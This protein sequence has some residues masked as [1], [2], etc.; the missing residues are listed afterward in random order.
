MLRTAVVILVLLF[1]APSPPTS[2]QQTAKGSIEGT[3]VRSPTG[4]P[5]DRARVTL[6]RISTA[7]TGPATTPPTPL[8]PIPPVQTLR[9][10][11]FSFKALD[12]GQYRLRVQRN[13]FAA[14]EY[15]Q[16][17]A[18]TPG[19]VINLTE[20]QQMN[21]VPFRLIPGA[22]VSGR[23][24]DSNGEPVPGFQ[25]SLM[26]TVYN[27]NGQRSLT[28]VGTDS[29]DDR[30]EYRVFWVPPGRYLLSVRGGATST[31]IIMLSNGEQVFTTSTNQ[32]V[33]SDRIF[34]VTY[35]PGTLDP[36]RASVVDLQ[37]GTE[38]GGIDIVLNQP[39]SF[40][41]R[42]R[43]VDSASSKP[44]QGVSV[45][46]S[47]RQEAGA[48]G[49]VFA[50]GTQGNATYNAT[51][52]AFEILNVIPGTYWLRASMSTDM[53]EPVN[54][55]GTAR[56]AMELLDSVMMASTRSAQIP[57]E[58]TGSDI[59]GLV[60]P[61][62]PGISIPLRLHLEG[63]ELAAVNGLDR[64]RVNLRPTVPGGSTPYQAISFNAEGTA[65]LGNVSPGEYRVQVS[66]PS[67]EMYLK[68]V[69]FD[70]SDVLTRPWEITS[71]TSGT[72][73]IVFSNKGGQVEGTLLDVLSQP[74]RGN[75]VI[76]IPDEG[77]DRPEL[78]KTATTDA[79]GKFT[80]RGVAPGGYRAYSWESIEANAWYD[81]EI[82]S[83]YEPQGKSIRIQES[84]KEVVEL[85]LIPAPK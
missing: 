31:G 76:L 34:P 49:I 52:G 21:D 1:Q 67:P 41:I 79:S 5:L 16:K 36:S 11:K 60:V 10:G 29:T 73:N 77:R 28:N 63:Q 2:L 30:G 44:P 56:A 8:P 55:T 84:G 22:T 78:Y 46:I 37:P 9:D 42:G 7:P 50:S 47:P 83:K 38:L 85:R 61:L 23:V 74:V 72:L 80:L 53:N 15:G 24:R 54:L 40:R 17:S 57:I 48:T 3:V 35:Y 27:V 75:S 6:Q 82:L 26:R 25:V 19:A 45:F 66:A 69:V 51:N 20:G 81:R 43:I 33:F 64:V 71:Q 62:T 32:N 59:E 13:G 4:E 58:V 68:E 14:Q 18:T 70:R 39:A 12:P 65:V